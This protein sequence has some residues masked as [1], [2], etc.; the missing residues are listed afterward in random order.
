MTRDGTVARSDPTETSLPFH[1]DIDPA[2]MMR[3][4]FAD[5]IRAT[6]PSGLREQAGHMTASDFCAAR[7]VISC[8]AGGH[9]HMNCPPAFCLP[10]RMKLVSLWPIS[11]FWA[12]RHAEQSSH[13][14]RVF[15]ISDANSSRLSAA[16]HSVGRSWR[17]R[18]RPARSFASAFSV[19]ASITRNRSLYTAPSLG[20][21]ASLASAKGKTSPLN[22]EV[23][24]IP[25]AHSSLQR[26]SCG[27]NR[28]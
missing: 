12:N 7:E 25:V 28:I 1:W 23:W 5:S 15:F 27:H 16:R 24:R 6:S 21:C 8:Q 18:S 19:P 4:R 2:R 11:A 20:N 26:N 10:W 9:P 22:I 17:A 3:P 14:L 13:G